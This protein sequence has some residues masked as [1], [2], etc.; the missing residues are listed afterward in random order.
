MTVLGCGADVLEKNLCYEISIWRHKS[1]HRESLCSQ[2]GPFCG[3][4]RCHASAGWCGWCASWIRIWLRMPLWSLMPHFNLTKDPNKS[5]IRVLPPTL[6]NKKLLGSPGRCIKASSKR[7]K[8]MASNM[9]CGVVEC[10]VN[11]NPKLS[12][13]VPFCEIWTKSPSKIP[14]PTFAGFFWLNLCKHSVSFI[15]HVGIL[16]PVCTL[17]R[18]WPRIHRLSGKRRPRTFGNYI[19][20]IMESYGDGLMQ[21]LAASLRS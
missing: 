10:C 3:T 9:R 13:L 4:L 20:N 2:G 16:R 6:Q 11:K 1:Q 15:I 8:F 5:M 17:C 21:L 12:K 7:T 19:L 14:S 18:A